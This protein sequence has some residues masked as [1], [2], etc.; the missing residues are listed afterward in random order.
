MHKPVKTGSETSVL[1]SPGRKT[2]GLVTLRESRVNAAK[3]TV[4]Y[5]VSH[6]R[7]HW[8][9]KLPHYN[10]LNFVDDPKA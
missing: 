6:I 4:F 10:L 2:P 7:F 3:E 5:F 8:R 1:Q 9:L